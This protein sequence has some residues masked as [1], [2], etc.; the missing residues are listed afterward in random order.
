MAHYEL[1]QLNIAVARYPLDSAQMAPFMNNLD[2]INALAEE[3]P[4][5]VWRLQDDTGNATALRPFGEDTLVNLT[6]W[7]DLAS[8]KAYVY[9][10]EHAAFMR[11]RREWFEQ[12]PEPYMVLWWVPTGHRPTMEEAAERLN[13][14]RRDGPTPEA[15]T[16]RAG[17]APPGMAERHAGEET[18]V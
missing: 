13:L 15:F 10:T 7:A 9:R 6:V 14:L 3:S 17:F 11:R 5:F 1:A 4:G 16:F 18:N 8:V 12:P 2:R